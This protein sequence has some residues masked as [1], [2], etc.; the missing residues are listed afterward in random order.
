MDDPAFDFNA[1][2]A[3]IDECFEREADEL[4]VKHP[5]WP[6]ALVKVLHPRN[7]RM[8]GHSGRA[9]AAKAAAAAAEG[10]APSA[11]AAGGAGDAPASPPELWT[12]HDGS[13]VVSG[14][15]LTAVGPG[16]DAAWLLARGITCVVNCI[17]RRESKPLPADTLQAAGIKRYACLD[18]D[19][20]FKPEYAARLHEGADALAAGAGDGGKTL[21]HC[22]AG[23]SRSSTVMLLFLMKHRGMRLAEALVTAHTRRF[24]VYPALGFLKYLAAQEAALYPGQEPSMPADVL[25]LHR[26]SIGAAGRCAAAAGFV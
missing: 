14:A 2:M 19:D 11:G 12:E 5:E 24:Q 15:F 10:G 21:V 9:E 20:K 17:D 26:E 13:E 6:A 4:V 7:K 23:V 8:A 18:M 25:L 3:H 22:A 16:K 1:P